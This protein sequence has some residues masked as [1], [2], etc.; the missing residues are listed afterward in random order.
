LEK[1]SR[2][3]TDEGIDYDKASAAIQASLA[4]IGPDRL[5]VTRSAA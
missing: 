5:S 3:H 2:G 4:G 1:Q